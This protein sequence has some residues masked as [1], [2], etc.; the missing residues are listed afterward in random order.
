MSGD[1]RFEDGSGVGADVPRVPVGAG[2][3][4]T[5]SEEALT[6]TVTQP[7]ALDGADG[8][9]ARDAR[10]DLDG[11]DGLG[12]LDDLADLDTELLQEPGAWR[13]TDGDDGADGAADAG[14]VPGAR[15]D[16]P[17][18]S[19]EDRGEQASSRLA[20]PRSGRADAASRLPNPRTAQ[21]RSGVDPVK[22]LMHRHREL[23][24]RA[25]D[26]LEIAAGLEAHGVTDRTAA[27]YRHKDVF[28]LAEEM[29]ARMPRDG[30]PGEPPAAIPAPASGVRGAW[31]ALALLPGAVCALV[32]LALD[33]T[34]RTTHLAVAV[35]GALAVAAALRTT[36]RHGPLRSGDGPPAPATRLWVWWLLGYAVFGDGFLNAALAG[37]PDGAW[38][39]AT[40]PLLALAVAV[41][42]ATW[43]ARLFVAGARRRLAAS[44]GLAEFTSSVRPLLLGSVLLFA[45]VLAVLLGVAGAALDR[46]A[47]GSF[48]GAGTL[49]VLLLLARLLTAHGRTHAPTAVLGAAACAEALAVATVF[50]ARLPGCSFLGAPVETAVDAAGAGV[51][52]ATACAVAALALLIHATRTLT[53]ASAHAR[54]DNAAS[55]P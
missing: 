38:P 32:L 39:P 55:A 21:R 33:A 22:V 9:D 3:W 29:Y 26:P 49:G 17:V 31:A 50:A 28:S 4:G 7:P 30:E 43:C 46:S 37:G 23:C 41:A 47:Q 1:D 27:R 54:T 6:L 52:P 12:S 10:D 14:R 36:L 2:A 13:R 20:D 15:A 24:E 40:A 45:A 19:R 25:V 5:G 11:F 51:V 42:P 34:T 35:G 53:R 16:G 18:P 8:P 48:V 44:R